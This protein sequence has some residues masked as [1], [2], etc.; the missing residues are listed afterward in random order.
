M[1]GCVQLYNDN[2]WHIPAME[3]WLAIPEKEQ[4]R[5]TPL[6]ATQE[7]SAEEFYFFAYVRWLALHP[8][9]Q[10]LASIPMVHL[11]SIFSWTQC[12][13]LHN[14]ILFVSANTVCCIY[15]WSTTSSRAIY[16]LFLLFC[17]NSFCTPPLAQHPLVFHCVS[18]TSFRNFSFRWHASCRRLSVAIH[19]SP[20]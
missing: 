4:M 15:K 19:A 20:A 16:L 9:R 10:H 5:A 7:A 11:F 1:C 14:N 12:Y 8:L 2:V 3:Q 18:A 6:T 17:K 13:L